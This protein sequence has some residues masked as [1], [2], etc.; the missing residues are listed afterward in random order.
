MRHLFED[1]VLKIDEL[2]GGRIG[3]LLQNS[4]LIYNINN[5]KKLEE[6]KLPN[7]GGYYDERIAD[8]IELKNSDLVLWSPKKIFLYQLSG[9]K[10]NFYQSINGLEE[11]EENKEKNEEE[12]EEFVYYHDKR[13]KEHEINSVYELTN[14]KLVCCSS[15]GLL[16]Y[17]KDNGNYKFESKHE[18]EID[19]RKI[20]E[21]DANKL[22]LFQR[23]HY[24]WWG[25]SRNNYSSHTY[26]ISTYDIET[27]KLTQIA[28]NKVDKNNYY[29]YALI[30]FMIKNGLL[31]VRYGN[32]IDIYDI[33]NNMLLMNHDQEGMVKI[34]ESYYGKYKILKDEMDIIFLC[35][36]FDNFIITKNIKNIAKIH[37]IKDNS[38]NYIKDFPYQLED[39]KEIIKLKNNNLLMY[40]NRQL[41]ILNHK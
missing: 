23:Y 19:V 5:F 34:D 26:S 17:T 18:M 7:Q 8:F 16:I 10:Y 14:G 3:V 40:S 4:L 35:D 39:L 41:I 36:Y 2:S 24:F 29:G 9:N 30:S 1:K 28:S 15:I 13:D 22:I 25:C 27:K 38:F 20:I 21:I 32:R 12:N 33:K 11:K 31:F 37:M 6:I